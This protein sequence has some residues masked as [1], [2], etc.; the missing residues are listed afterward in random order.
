[1]K[2]V[3]N[4]PRRTEEIDWRLTERI[5]RI[6]PSTVIIRASNI[7]D[8]TRA[9]GNS[10][11]NGSSKNMLNWREIVIANI[12]PIISPIMQADIVTASDS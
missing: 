9:S 7:M 4:Y 2:V 1:M 12:N 11:K 3:K 10:M 5:G 6:V 8:K